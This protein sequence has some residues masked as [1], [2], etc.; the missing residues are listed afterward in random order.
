M[1]RIESLAREFSFHVFFE[2]A[3]LKRRQYTIYTVYPVTLFGLS[4]A[5]FDSG[6]LKFLILDRDGI[7]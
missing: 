6:S 4:C 3:S 2:K 5:P 1:M 7:S